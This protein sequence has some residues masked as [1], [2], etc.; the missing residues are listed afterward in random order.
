MAQAL[1]NLRASNV[2]RV[3]IGFERIPHREGE[4]VGPIPPTLTDAT[5]GG[6]VKCLC[7]PVLA[8]EPCDRGA[9]DRGQL[10]QLHG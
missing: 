6:A 10:G 2:S 3:V 4:K 1:L 8:M 9:H 7:R 5:L